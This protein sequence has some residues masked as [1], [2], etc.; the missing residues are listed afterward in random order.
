MR[1]ANGAADFLPFSP[2]LGHI[3]R[4]ESWERNNLAGPTA[5]A[6]PSFLYY[7]PA[8]QAISEGRKVRAD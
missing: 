2:L 3:R 8:P 4:K 6:S 7:A 5:F 1:K